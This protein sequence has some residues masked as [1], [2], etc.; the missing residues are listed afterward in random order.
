MLIH[1]KGTPYEQGKAHGAATV[2][3]IR[4]NIEAVRHIVIDQ[5]KVNFDVYRKYVQLNADFIRH[6]RPDTYEELQGIAEGSGIPLRD[7]FLLNIQLFFVTESLPQ[8]CTTIIA[9]GPATLDGKTYVVK[10]RDIGTYFHHVVLHR[11]Y[12]NGIT[13]CEVDPAGTVLWPGS[14]IN[15]FG[16][17]VSTTSGN[18]PHK[19][20]SNNTSHINVAINQNY[21]LQECRNVDDVIAYMEEKHKLNAFRLNVFGVDKERAVCIETTETGIAVVE[22]EQGLLMRTNHFHS[23]LQKQYNPPPGMYPSTYNRYRRGMEFLTQRR[24][25]LRFQDL[26]QIASDHE[27]GSKGAICRHGGEDATTAYC[28]ICVVEDQQLWTALGNPCRSLILSTI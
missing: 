3:L 23:A 2:D 13:T 25:T 10:N 28:S 8:D 21:L 26:L 9:H 24:G 27:G 18:S 14:G 20:L 1:L 7:I 12:P 11:E 4:K 15:N 17:A 19:P 5:K 16:L 22:S 6:D